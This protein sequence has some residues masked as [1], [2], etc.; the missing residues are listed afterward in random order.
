MGRSEDV[1]RLRRS[2]ASVSLLDALSTPDLFG[3][4]FPAPAWDAWRV[5]CAALAGLP[6]SEADQALFTSC[7]GR[8]TPPA[9][10]AREAWVICGRR[11]GKSRIAAAIAAYTAALAPT[12]R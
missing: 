7:T 4:F 8:Q 3:P 11:S 2:V 6:V 9:T 5:F 12:D 1:R 10:P